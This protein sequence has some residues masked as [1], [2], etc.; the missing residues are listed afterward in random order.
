MNYKISSRQSFC[1]YFIIVSLTIGTPS[2]VIS[3][4]RQD[5]WQAILL[6][7]A[8][9]VP[10]GWFL[11][12]LGLNYANQT[13]FQYSERILGKYLGKVSI[14]VF[15]IYFIMVAISLVQAL[16]DFF[17]SLVMPET[18]KYAFAFLL[19]LV[20]T[21]ACCAGIEVIVRLAEIIAPF[22]FGSFLFV[23]V[24]NIKNVD[25]HNLRPVFQHGLGEIVKGS[26][27]P[28]AWFG[29]CIIMGVL[30]AYHNNPKA[31]LK[32]KLMGVGLGVFTLL[33]TMFFVT[34]VMGVEVASRQMYSVYVLAR[35]VSV[36]EFIER[37]EAFQMA[38]WIAGCFLILALF[39]YAGVEGLRYLFPKRS[40]ML[41]GIGV[42]GI[43]FATSVFVN[44]TSYDKS[45]FMK[46]IFSSYGLAVEVVGVTTLYIIYVLKKK[47][48][49]AK[50][51]S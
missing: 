23:M 24:F 45:T 28:A 22:V 6:A 46:E 31:M 27:V 8:V 44:P 12:K 32:V 15:I 18:P 1:T 36:G 19:L 40:R 33:A 41:L 16:I 49:A 35:L 26:M 37:M 17:G 14:G 34:M 4:L 13:I 11:Y 3:D 7:L 29:V 2:Y 42:A 5:F 48:K 50:K 20:S 25:I 21:Y 39:Q 9:E 51:R 47:F 10:L 30:M 38:S 43:I